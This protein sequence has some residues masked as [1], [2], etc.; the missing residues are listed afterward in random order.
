[1]EFH[2]A[3]DMYN[4]IWTDQALSI[5]EIKT[6]NQS[7]KINHF[8]EITQITRK[9]KMAINLNAMKTFFTKVLN[10]IF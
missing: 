9:N 3:E 5:K 8:P 7:T 4:M 6:E 1:M 2:V 10:G